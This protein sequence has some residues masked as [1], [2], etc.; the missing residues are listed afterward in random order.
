MA[1]Y[2]NSN[3]F[4]DGTLRIRSRSRSTRSPVT[5]GTGRGRLGELTACPIEVPCIPFAWNAAAL[6]PDIVDSI[7]GRRVPVPST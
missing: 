5:G 4:D 2:V 7:N 3:S 6:V 1:R